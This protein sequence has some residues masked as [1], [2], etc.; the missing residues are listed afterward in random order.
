[1]KLKCVFGPRCSLVTSEVSAQPFLALLPPP[2]GFRRLAIN[3]Y[4]T[5]GKILNIN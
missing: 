2:D 4:K 5:I 3:E 1:M